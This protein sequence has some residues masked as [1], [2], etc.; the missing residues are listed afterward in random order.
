M[1][2]RFL[3]SY[4]LLCV[5]PFL[6]LGI[7]VANISREAIEKELLNAAEVALDES[8]R[9]IA[10]LTEEARQRAL[11]V[12]NSAAVQ[13][14]LQALAEEEDPE[15]RQ[16]HFR[17]LNDVL[18]QFPSSAGYLRVHLV[19]TSDR[20]DER[21]LALPMVSVRPSDCQEDWYRKAADAPNGFHWSLWSGSDAALR[22]SKM[23]YSARNWTDLVGMVVVDVNPEELRG[24]A[25]S[26]TRSANRLY[27]V[28]GDGAII[29]PYYNYDKIPEDIL[30]APA[31]VY[32]VGD[33]Q[34]LVRGMAGTGWNLIKIVALS[35]L[36]GRTEQIQITIITVA[37]LFLCLSV[38][39]AV[40][41]SMHISGP[42]SRLAQKMRK[43][44]AGELAPVE[45][46]P[47]KGEVGELYQSFNYMI[48][49]LNAQ[50]ERTY[51]SQINE[52]DAE[53]R[54][55]QAQ[56]NPHVLYNTLDSINWLALRCRA[57]DI[58]EMV[59]ALS[60][61]LRLSL[62][63]GKNTILLQDE[64]RQVDSYIT[65]QKVRY[66]NRF[67]VRYEVEEGAR[68]RR[69]IKMLL[70]P[71]VEN[72][73]VHGFEDI[74]SGG[75]IVIGVTRGEGLLHFSVRNN[76]ALID[77]EKAAQR[78]GGAAEPEGSPGGYG[79]RNVNERIKG[80]YGAQ[81]GIRYAIRDGMTAAE[82]SIPEEVGEHD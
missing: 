15:A 76:G 2:K 75:V 9:S 51:I 81:Y 60:D 13:G 8:W 4:C 53:L 52:K 14:R 46:G 12:A 24:I 3:L 73:I 47:Q 36:K 1:L 61:M 62:N 68:G 41:F 22:Q 42:L 5:A 48:D 74:E 17:A 54:A 56:I 57:Y 29:Y 77:L 11:S 40:Y 18:E 27:L 58:S 43:A 25:V 44:R 6:L 72:A 50:I 21:E 55:L 59:V 67:S 79:I 63:K 33:K 69:I 38:A 30:T 64:L 7:L 10:T 28:D 31:G 26:Q 37:A 65:L 39:A 78:L 71:I 66:S 23:I 80:T 82:F 49:H 70:Q 20:E 16:A 45:G 32:Q 35:E 19:L 34:L